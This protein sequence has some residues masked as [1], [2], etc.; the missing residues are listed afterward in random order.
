MSNCDSRHMPAYIQDKVL[1][2]KCQIT[3]EIIH[4]PCS[5]DNVDALACGFEGFRLGATFGFRVAII[6]STL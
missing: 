3:S 4:A 2:A 6:L 5:F 1:S